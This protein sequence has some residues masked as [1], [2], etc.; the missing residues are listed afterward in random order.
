M[1]TKEIVPLKI[2]ADVVYALSAGAEELYGIAVQSDDEK[3]TTN[4]FSYAPAL[5]KTT[6]LLKL[7]DED[8]GAFTYVYDGHVF[9]DIGGE[10]LYS[11]DLS[12]KKSIVYER[13]ASLPIK[14][15][16]N[17]KRI[18]VLNRDGSISWYDEGKTDVLADWYLTRDGTW[19]EF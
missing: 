18:A 2:T 13:S 7:N 8:T 12:R 9:T 17:G 1:R 5:S 14:A 3:K 16:Q 15:V 4:L 11:Y 6:M 10:K 19:Y